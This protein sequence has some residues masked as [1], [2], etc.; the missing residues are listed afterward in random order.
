MFALTKKK[1]DLFIRKLN[2]EFYGWKDEGKTGFDIYEMIPKLQKDIFL[3]F[4]NKP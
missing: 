3:Y 1:L 2:L 4:F